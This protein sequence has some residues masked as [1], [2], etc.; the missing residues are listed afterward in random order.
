M[1]TYAIQETILDIASTYT[2]ISQTVRQNVDFFIQVFSFHLIL[3]NAGW[4]AADLH[5]TTSCKHNYAR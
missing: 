3:Q 4:Q 2:R 5:G 1:R